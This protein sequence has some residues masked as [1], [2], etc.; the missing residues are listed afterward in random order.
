MGLSPAHKLTSECVTEKRTEDNIILDSLTDRLS[1]TKH[2]TQE[3]LKYESE[4]STTLQTSLKDV[5][6][7]SFKI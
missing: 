7:V 1:E 5:E 4:H 2:Q 3:F 6:Q